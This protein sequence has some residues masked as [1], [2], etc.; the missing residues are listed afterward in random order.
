MHHRSLASGRVVGDA[1]REVTSEIVTRNGSP[2]PLIVGEVLFDCFSER[3]VLGGAP[4]NVAWN[5]RGLGLDPLLATAVGDDPLGREVRQRMSQWKLDETALQVDR[6]HA[7]GRVEIEIREGEP[8][9]QF[10]DDVAYDHIALQPEIFDRGPF[11]LLY[12]GSLALRG[13][14]SRQTI[15]EL[16]RRA[17]CPVFV[18]VNIR[19][20]YF[21]EALIEPML[22]GAEH[23]KLNHDELMAL[24]PQQDAAAAG[25][26]PQ[27]GGRWPQRFARGRGL[28]ARYGISN[29]WITAGAEGAAWIGPQGGFEQASGPPL[30]NLVDTVGAGDALAAVI[31]RGILSGQPPAG[32]LADAVAFAAR[33]CTLR[34]ATTLDPGFYSSPEVTR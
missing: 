20:P 30:E 2:R 34:G 18:D 13:G 19:Q 28:Q 23:V 26:L 22:G 14:R 8:V 12:H 29:L 15:F 32:S 7:T 4:L 6:Q 16:R 24:A 10:W 31:I 33:I 9:Y 5:L 21:D 27:A 25:P 11:G 3:R 1:V 17:G